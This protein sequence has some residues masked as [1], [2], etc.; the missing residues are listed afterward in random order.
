V[1]AR[2]RKKRGEQQGHPSPAPREDP[3][4]WLDAGPA[5]ELAK[6]PLQQ[7]RVGRKVFAVSCVAGRFHALNG[8]CN[9]AGGPLGEGQLDAEGYVVCPWHYWRFHHATGKGERGFEEDTVPVHE[10]RV[11]AGRLEIRARASTRRQRKPHAPHPLTQM[12]QRGEPGGPGPDAPLRLLGIST[13]AMDTGHPRYSTSDDLLA[14][15][16]ARAGALGCETRLVRLAELRFRHCEGF[17]SKSARACTWP[18]SITQLDPTDQM[19]RVYE[20]V[21]GWSDIVL[22]ATP[23]RWGAASSLYYKMVE[24][25][26]CVQNQETIAGRHLM[27]L[28]VAGFIVTGGQDNVQAVVGQM[29]G[30]FAELGCQFP[31]FPFIAHSRGWSA[32]DMENNAR[33]VQR[34]RDLHAG[35]ENLVE[36]CVE[37]ARALIAGILGCE[38]PVH[39][40]R[41]GRQLD[42]RAQ[43]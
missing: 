34:S 4:E 15:A 42:V 16:L 19:D 40:G 3:Q 32:E 38:L 43:V 24:R 13:T 27:R 39:G 36:R 2:R 23:I 21:V 11:R 1:A 12:K 30:F 14:S 20:S 26:N 6:R 31:Q 7:I 41:K 35:A 18:C 5:E 37:T 17:Y 29:L 25:M 33:Y 22:V 8:S 10:T 28:K 9:H